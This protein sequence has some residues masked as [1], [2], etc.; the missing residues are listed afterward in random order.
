MKVNGTMYKDSCAVLLGVTES[1]LPKFG[2]V[3]EILIDGEEVLFVVKVYRTLSY[4]EH[5][6]AYIIKLLD[7]V[8]TISQRELY[9]FMPLHVR[10][11]E[12]LTT[13]SQRAVILKHHVSTL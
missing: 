7:E 10:R 9:S 13:A 1:I 5:F 4:S 3:Q 11:I 8:L 2:A 6:N 12:G